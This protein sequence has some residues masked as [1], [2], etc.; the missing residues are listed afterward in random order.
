M[1]HLQ[2]IE[3]DIVPVPLRFNCFFILFDKVISL[4]LFILVRLTLNNAYCERRCILSSF[5]VLYVANYVASALH[6]D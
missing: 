5:V 4:R 6:R 1:A 2:K 3:K